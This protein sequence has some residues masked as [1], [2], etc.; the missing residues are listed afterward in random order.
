MLTFDAETHT[1][2]WNGRLVRSVT[3]VLG[4]AHPSPAR[5]RGAL[6]RGRAVHLAILYWLQGDLH[7]DSV[8][9]IARP[10]F[11]AFKRFMVDTGFKPHKELCEKPMYCPE[12]D[13]AGTPDL[14][15]ILFRCGSL[16]DVKTGSMGYAAKQTALYLR[17]PELKARRIKKRYGLVLK[18]NGLYRLERFDKATDI[19][20]A[21]DDVRRFKEAA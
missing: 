11:A 6:D 16:V 18:V 13:I 20:E 10:Y 15:G 9:P 14:P 7:E 21:L 5:G 4:W 2:T 3:E 1:Y 17:F 19:A 12:L 8:S